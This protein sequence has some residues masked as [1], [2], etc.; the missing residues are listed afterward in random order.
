M[1]HRKDVWHA[2]LFAIIG[3]LF[4]CVIV[5]NIMGDLE[6]GQNDES[7]WDLLFG[8]RWKLNKNIT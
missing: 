2:V 8:G 6:E 5:Y 3:I 7:F 4:T 1:K